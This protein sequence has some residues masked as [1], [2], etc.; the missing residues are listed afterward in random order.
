MMA[1]SLDL[2]A[3][4]IAIYIS[5]SKTTY[6]RTIIT[7][8]Q[9]TY[10]SHSCVFTLERQWWIR[11]QIS[12]VGEFSHYTNRLIA[13]M[14]QW[15]LPNTPLM[16][17]WFTFKQTNPPPTNGPELKIMACHRPFFDPLQCMY[18][19]LNKVQFGRWYYKSLIAAH[20]K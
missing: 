4:V 16:H 18:L 12:W 14:H 20:Q 13:E 5:N 15:P 10:Q 3:M 1:A 17:F 19:W 8:P 7:P 2:V 6:I 11:H 9:W